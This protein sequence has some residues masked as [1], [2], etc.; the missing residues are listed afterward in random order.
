MCVRVCVCFRKGTISRLGQLASGYQ[1]L[2]FHGPIKC[3]KRGKNVDW[4]KIYHIFILAQ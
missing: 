3:N 1:T 2:G 4:D